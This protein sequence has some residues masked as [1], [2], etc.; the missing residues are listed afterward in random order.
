MGAVPWRVPGVK[1]AIIVPIIIVITEMSLKTGSRKHLLGVLPSVPPG[2]SPMNG[3][4]KFNFLDLIALT[5]AIPFPGWFVSR[6]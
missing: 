6:V 4:G 3:R 5:C 2:S 1:K